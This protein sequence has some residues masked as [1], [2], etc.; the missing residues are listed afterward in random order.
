MKLYH[1]NQEILCSIVEQEETDDG[2]LL[3]LYPYNNTLIALSYEA[4]AQKPWINV[5]DSK[6]NYRIT[7]LES[8]ILDGSGL[9]SMELGRVRP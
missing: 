7:T 3:E 8:Y 4:H 6:I 1:N 5:N 2:W 9:V